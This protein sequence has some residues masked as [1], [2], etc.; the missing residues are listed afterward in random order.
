T[1]FCLDIGLL[2]IDKYLG[3]CPA[4]PVYRDVIVRTLNYDTQ[5][6]LPRSLQNRLCCRVLTGPPLSVLC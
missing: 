3:L 6:G 2:K 4:N 1:K 5:F